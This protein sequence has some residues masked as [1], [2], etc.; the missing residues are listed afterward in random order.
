MNLIRFP[1]G[2]AL[3]VAALTAAVPVPAAEPDWANHPVNEWVKQSPR[4]GAPVP[5]VGW[6]GSAAFDPR[7]N[8]WL[9]HAG[10]DGIPQ[11]F[12]LFR[13]D[14]ASGRWEQRFPG[15]S[16]PGACCVDGAATFDIVND[17]F[18]RFPGA[19]LGHGYQWSRGVKL[20][21]SAVWLYDPHRNVWTNMRPPPYRPPLNARD[22][23]GRLNGGAAY[24]PL[25]GL[26]LSFGGQGNAGGT[27]NLFVYDAHANAL[28]RLPAANP[29]SPR[30]GMGL[31]YDAKNDCLVM[32]GSQYD[33]DEKT[34]IYRYAARR[35]EGHA[36]DPHP[37]GKKLGTYAT[38]P[39]LAWD[40]VNGVCLCVVW[41]TS[42][43]EHQTW[44]FDAAKLRWTK[45]SPPAEPSPS[46]SRSRNLAFSAEH[47]VFLLELAPKERKGKG[48]ELWSY[49]YGK[50][51][52]GRSPEAP[53]GIEVVTSRD[54]ASLKWPAVRSAV[55]GYHVYRAEGAPLWQAKFARVGLVH[56]PSYED[57]GLAAGQV[58]HY[59][60]AAVAADG[61][62]GPPSPPART[63]PRVLAAPVVSVLGKDRIEVSWA[64]SP[65]GDVA[66]YN[67]YRG[68][69]SVRT[70]KK[71]TL[72]PWKDNDPEYAEP[73]PVEVR[74]ITE[75]R[76]LN[77]RPLTVTAWTDEVDLTRTGPE[78]S[79]Y[80]YA[81]HAYIV[82]AVNRLG[83]ESGPSPYAL[84]IPSAPTGVFN[85]ERG[86]TAQLKWDV[87]PE[88]GIAGYHVY[89]LEGT[90]GIV[91]VTPEPVKET[92]FQHEGGGNAT[93]YWVVAVDVLGQEGEPSSPVWHNQSYKGFFQGEW[94]Q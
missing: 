82:R 40:S 27:N 22:D 49:R 21:S 66:G 3:L 53:Q 57:R 80:R 59:R 48:V 23:L 11:G 33:N 75:I 77:D 72:A 81:V 45:M 19:S 52:A 26:C 89:K 43:G 38:I 87:S 74:D 92:T 68:L 55:K 31:A 20:K 60:V 18:V 2:A 15:T 62:Q 14:L 70:V 54:G 36:L 61:T 35:W 24:D 30:D 79:G 9:H 64:P 39:R 42:S 93:R 76:K 85:R 51:P 47:N 78:S 34:W 65:A 63:Q 5:P 13:C 6:E 29:P 56:D 50:R 84:T 25:R 32:F 88:K 28:H 44:A 37:P 73:L 67:V 69:V 4:E 12:H 17:R 94:H 90:W 8:Q 71:G 91:R 46:M 86:K 1:P 10:H 58:Y 7:R 41:D 83:T 16:P